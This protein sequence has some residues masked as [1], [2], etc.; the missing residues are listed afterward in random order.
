[1]DWQL[2]CDSRAC[3]CTTSA[4][5][6]SLAVAVLDRRWESR[7]VFPKSEEK[8]LTPTR[9]GR[10]LGEAYAQKSAAAVFVFVCLHVGTLA[11]HCRERASE[12]GARN[13]HA[14]VL[15]STTAAL[16]AIP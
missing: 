16:M 3:N 9:S 10:T 1:M 11:L 7:R 8:A 5:Q 4:T 12:I 15:Y 13:H 14:R 6:Q 2:L